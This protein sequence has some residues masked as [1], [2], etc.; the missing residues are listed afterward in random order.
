MLWHRSAPTKPSQDPYEFQALRTTRTIRLVK[1]CRT[2][3]N[4]CIACTIHHFDENQLRNLKYHALSY[5]WGD[6]TPTR[7]V[8]LRDQ[9]TDWH[10]LPL[11]EN[12]WQFLDHAW[13]RKNFDRLFWTDRLCLDQKSHEE[14]SQQV[15]RMRAI[16]HSA[17]LV[18]VWLNLGRKEQQ[19]LR[20]LVRWRR[21]ENFMPE[22]WQTMMRNRLSLTAND[23]WAEMLGNPFWQRIWIVQ[24][25]VLAKK[26]CVKL[27]YV[28]IDLDQLPSLFRPFRMD[29]VYNPAQESSFWALFN[30]RREGGILP[31][32]RILTDFSEYHSSRPADR[33]YGL[34][35]MVADHDDGNSP[36]DNILVDYDKPTMHVMLDA[37][38]ESSPPMTWYSD[39]DLRV[40][41]QDTCESISQLEGYISS[42]KT[43]QRHRGFASLALQA[44]EAFDIIKS[45]PCRLAP[46]ER[47]RLTERFLVSAAKTKWKPTFAQSAALAGILI[48]RG[49]K[50]RLDAVKAHRQR[51]G[52]ASSPWRCYTHRSLY[53]YHKG[54]ESNEL[55]V[56]TVWAAWDREG[57]V[58]ACGEQSQSCEG[59]TMTFAIPQ[60]GLLLLVETALNRWGCLRL[61]RLKD[62]A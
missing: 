8:Y 5:V 16:Y 34:L 56:G 50:A 4:E 33:L 24:E 26:V 61:F 10:P 54:L 32:W 23:I 12:L 30:M 22:F 11:H 52:E 6:P 39:A 29:A 57:I 3:V 46:W 43:I 27:E 53:G 58:N 51:R 40:G 7:Q 1:L 17:E 25:V 31:L 55:V 48:S 13:R 15:P 49:T 28:T 14:I 41:P 18:V 19:G 2:K 42:S 21:D 45:V 35:G 38:F 20:K 47:T 9:G 62:Q 59:S 44:L 37:V 36:V 60:I